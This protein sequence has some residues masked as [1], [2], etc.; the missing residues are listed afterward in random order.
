MPSFVPP[1]V[2]YNPVQTSAPPQSVLPPQY[3]Q[4]PPAY[5]QDQIYQPAGGSVPSYASA[6][7][8]HHQQQQQQQQYPPP[9]PPQQQSYRSQ[10]QPAMPRQAVQFDESL[11][12]D[13][14]AMGYPRHKVIETLNKLYGS[15]KPCNDMNILLDSLEG[16]VQVRGQCF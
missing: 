6:Y 10:S 5:V 4:A 13:A 15:S 14:C 11:I 8:H 9:P 2:T 12:S 16:Y 3:S 1:E 7:S